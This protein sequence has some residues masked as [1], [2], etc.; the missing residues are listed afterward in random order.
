MG[1]QYTES[2][3]GVLKKTLD[4]ASVAADTTAEQ[5]FT[6]K[7]LTTDMFVS[8]NKPSATAGVGIVGAR[9]SAADTLAIT[10]ANVTGLA[11]DPASEDY[12]VYWFLPERAKA[13]LPDQVVR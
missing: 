1:V 7:G 13:N 5:T 4:P 8:V 12:L 11:V 10:F 9:V 2:R 6:V 3:Y